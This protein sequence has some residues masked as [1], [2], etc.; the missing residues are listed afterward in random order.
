MTGQNFQ[1]QPQGVLPDTDVRS[2]CETG[3]ICA[4]E[5]DHDQI[6]PASIDLRLGA[7]AYRMRASFLPG[8]GRKVSDFFDD[9]LVMHELD[10][11][12]GAVLETGCVYLVPLLESLNL[13][14]DLTGAANPK[15]S[16]GRIDVFVRMVTDGADRFELAPAGYSG[17]LYVEISPRTFS[18]LA[19]TG[20]RLLQ[21]R[22]RRGPQQVL[23]EEI[24]SVDLKPGDDDI[25]G[26][27]AKRHSRILDLSKVGQHAVEDFWEPVRPH[28]GALI[29]DPG[30]FYI[31]ASK[32]FTVIPVMEAAEMAPIAP[33]FGEFRAHYAGFFDPG[34]GVDAPEGRAVL[35]VRSREVPFILA[36]GQPMG[37]LVFEP[38]TSAPAVPY[39]HAG[40]F[41]NYQGQ[42]LKLSKHF[43]MRS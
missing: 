43:A 33:E 18:I 3:V 19:R 20:D 21:L 11:T 5:F 36:D 13:P 26:Y 6:Q 34:F 14:D 41:S 10:L 23:R 4:P 31:L 38:M 32:E 28:R 24:F 9:N 37:R 12:E 15:S 22:L 2:L 39:G 35:E 16:T 17:P 8:K 42:G 40:S 29:L 30:E 25:A 27:R 7:R 1:N